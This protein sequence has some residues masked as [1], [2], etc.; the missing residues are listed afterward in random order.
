MRDVDPAELAAIQAGTVV[1]RTLV[2][3]TVKDRLTGN[4]VSLGFYM[5]AGPASFNVVN[6]RTG[7][8][9]G[10]SFVGDAMN[11]VGDIPLT[12]D[13]SVREVE[14]VLAAIDDSVQNAVRTYD[15]RSAPIEI[16]RVYL[17]P[18]TMAQV[19]PAR[20]R[21]LGQVDTAP[22][23]TAA[24]GGA[25]TVALSCTSTTQE[26]R[27]K[28]PDVAS[29]ESQILRKSDDDFYRDTGVAGDWTLFWGKK[30]E[31]AGQR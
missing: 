28:N 24:E 5:D 12:S 21:F 23:E 31:K 17:D 9:E 2:T 14:V 25:S 8:V 7:A 16:H 18:L 4:P 19:A 6:P 11:S 22:I 15:A 13:I 29:H 27:R 10:R 30:Q 26:L 3:M 1:A 20:C